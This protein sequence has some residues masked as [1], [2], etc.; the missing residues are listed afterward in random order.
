[1]EAEFKQETL[2]QIISKCFNCKQIS[3]VPNH[4]QHIV[5]FLLK[6]SLYLR[7]DIKT[8]VFFKYVT[9]LFF[10]HKKAQEISLEY[11]IEDVV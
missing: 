7:S 6:T 5:D 1:M 11:K 10:G 3:C 4:D 2:I 9:V 8:K